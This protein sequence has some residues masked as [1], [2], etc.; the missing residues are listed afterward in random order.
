M[1]Q[2]IFLDGEIDAGIGDSLIVYK[3]H[4]SLL[5]E[6]VTAVTRNYQLNF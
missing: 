4:N 6:I 2:Q 5:Y 3:Q 1:A